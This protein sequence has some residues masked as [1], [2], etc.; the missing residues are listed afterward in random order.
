MSASNPDRGQWSSKLTFVLAAAGSAIGLGNIWRFPYV[1]AENGGGAFVLIYLAVVILLG[2]PV[3]LL[4][5]SLGRF[6]QKNPVGAI[7]A[8]RRRTPWVIVGFLGVFTGVAILSYY[9][10]VAGWTVG[11]LVKSIGFHLRTADFGTFIA[12]APV[13]LGY[14]AFFLIATVGVVAGGVRDGIER[15]T[16]ILMPVL[17]VLMLLLIARSLTLDGAMAGLRFYLI[18]DFSKITSHTLIYAIGQGFFS[19]SLG[20]GAMITYGSYLSKRE[21]LVSSAAWVCS[22]DTL[23]AFLAGLIIFPALGG[24][25]AKGGPTL[26]FVV[27]IDIFNNMPLGHWAAILFF[28]LLAIAAL[29]STVSLLEVATA[30]LVDE[31]NMSRRKAVWLVGGATALLGIPSALSQGAVGFLSRL[32]PK[33]DGH[34]G[35]LDIM[36]FL[37]GNISLTLGALLLCLFGVYVWKMRH[38]V[39]EVV[40]GCEGFR[41]WWQ[42]WR[43]ALMILAPLAIGTMIVYIL[44]TGETLG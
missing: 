15:M 44:V 4:E 21:N 35:F 6:S 13:Q 23:I 11:Y 37:F 9:T 29:T 19:L 28:F 38:A 42:L 5:L 43:L 16:R 40:Q 31:R 18:P 39:A 34:M 24:A 26:V 3:M 10:V 25:P 12:D 17:L 8:V 2:F 41:S 33:G 20:M 14:F 22:F 7:R 30:Y 32:I 36:D 27:L 1:T